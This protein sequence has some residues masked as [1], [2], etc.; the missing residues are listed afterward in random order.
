LKND[1]L[2]TNERVEVLKAMDKYGFISNSSHGILDIRR[3]PKM[4]LIM[5]VI[6]S[7]IHGYGIQTI[8]QMQMKRREEGFKTNSELTLQGL[9]K[10]TLIIHQLDYL[11]M[12]FQ[13]KM[14]PDIYTG[15]K[16]SKKKINYTEYLKYR[17]SR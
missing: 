17:Y 5:E 13:K 11:P 14:A 15:C 12:I 6:S 1:L 4:L 10:I 9:L 7:F 3:Y 2:L 8:I 16:E